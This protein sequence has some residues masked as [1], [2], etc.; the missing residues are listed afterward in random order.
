MCLFTNQIKPLINSKPIKAYK[1]IAIAPNK[2]FFWG[3]IMGF[4]KYRAPFYKGFDYTKFIHFHRTVSGPIP[5]AIGNV[6]NQGF[7]LC[8]DIEVAEYMKRCYDVYNCWVIF[9]CEIPIG[10]KYFVNDDNTEIC[11]NQFKF[12]KKLKI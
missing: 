1:V 7:H 3:T 11:T 5:K 9:E 6:V 12:K 10:S 8:L 2:N 4:V